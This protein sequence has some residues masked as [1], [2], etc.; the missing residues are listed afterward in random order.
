MGVIFIIFRDIPIKGNLTLLKH[1]LMQFYCE[2]S[3]KWKGVDMN[4]LGLV[5]REVSQH[6]KRYVY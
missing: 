5:F 4:V 6:N 2:V 1:A 3:K